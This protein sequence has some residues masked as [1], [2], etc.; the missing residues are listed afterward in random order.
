LRGRSADVVGA[1]AGKELHGVTIP[2]HPGV[3]QK[4]Q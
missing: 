3:G 1:S 4:A 2:L